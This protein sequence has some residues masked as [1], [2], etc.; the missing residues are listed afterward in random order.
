LG[1]FN[2]NFRAFADWDFNLKCFNDET[3]K[4]KYIDLIVAEFNSDGFSS[5]FADEAFYKHIRKI[6]MKAFKSFSIVK[7]RH[8][9]AEK[10]AINEVIT[11]NFYCGSYCLFLV[12]LVKK[13]F[14]PQSVTIAYWLKERVKK[15]LQKSLPFS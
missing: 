1:G 3:I 13:E 10:F 12:S 8:P 11:G 5:Y 6:R 2:V 7:D 14:L 4:T 9:F 15:K